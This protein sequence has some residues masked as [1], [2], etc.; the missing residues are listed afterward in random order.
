M[1]ECLPMHTVRTSLIL[2]NQ[3]CVGSGYENRCAA[4]MYIHAAHFF[5]DVIILCELS[6]WVGV[7]LLIN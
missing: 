5:Y 4:W 6:R 7:R 1:A 2:A 3:Y